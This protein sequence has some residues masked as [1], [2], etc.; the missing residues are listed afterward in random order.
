MLVLIEIADVL[1]TGG[2]ELRAGIPADERSGSGKGVGRSVKV[3]D[4]PVLIYG[5]ALG[6][7]VE[8]V[9]RVDHIAR[10]AVKDAYIEGGHM[11]VEADQ[12]LKRGKIRNI[13]G[14]DQVGL[15]VEL[16]DKGTV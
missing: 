5:G 1:V 8:P 2:E 3:G 14:G 16:P 15:A 9:L 13:E 10:A 7:D 6:A 4:L 12:P 11:I